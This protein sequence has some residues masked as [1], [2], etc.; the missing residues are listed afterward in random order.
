[1]ELKGTA[2]SPPMDVVL[3][4]RPARFCLK[5]GTNALVTRIAPIRFVSIAISFTPGIEAS[6]VS[7]FGVRIVAITFQPLPANNLAAARPR[8]DELPVMKIVFC[9]A[10]IG[11]F[12]HLLVKL[13]RLSPFL[14][15]RFPSGRQ[16][17]HRR[18]LGRSRGRPLFP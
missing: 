15:S 1:M 5:Y 13:F 12:L 9:E 8:P 2:I 10:V 11:L 6:S 4:N 14:S 16:G 3:M 18:A 7:F 17:N